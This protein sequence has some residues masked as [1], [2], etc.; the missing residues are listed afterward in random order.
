M[1]EDKDLKDKEEDDTE[2][3]KH[4]RGLT[5]EET[6]DDTEGQKHIRGLT[7]E[8]TADDTEGQRKH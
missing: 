2:G 5:V 3:Q 1:A 4:I 6:A 8:E 7:V